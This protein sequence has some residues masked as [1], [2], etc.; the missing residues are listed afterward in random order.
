[1][2][3]GNAIGITPKCLQYFQ[4]SDFS[5]IFDHLYGF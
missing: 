3:K 4:Q 2:C 1:M 5:L